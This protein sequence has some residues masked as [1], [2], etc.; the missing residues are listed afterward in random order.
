M[1]P[2]A[3][4]VRVWIGGLTQIVYNT[5]EDLHK[6]ISSGV[7]LSVG[8]A[9]PGWDVLDVQPSTSAKQVGGQVAKDPTFKALACVG[10]R[11][12]LPDQTAA[13]T[14]V[15]HAFVR[16]PFETPG[17]VNKARDIFSVFWSIKDRL[18]RFRVPKLE[19]FPAS[20]YVCA[21][22]VPSSNNPIGKHVYMAAGNQ[23]IG[24]I[25]ETFDSP[26]H[27]ERFPS[28]YQHDLSLIKATRGHTLPEVLAPSG[29]PVVDGWASIEEA[30]E[31]KPVFV[32][33]H[34]A[35]PRNRSD[36]HGHVLTKTERQECSKAIQFAIAE[37]VSYHFGTEKDTSTALLWRTV[38]S[39]HEAQQA[40]GMEDKYVVPFVEAPR[41]AVGFSGS[42]L[43][44]GTP[45]D[46]TAKAIVMQNFELNWPK[47][48]LGPN[49]EIQSVRLI[50][51][52]F[53]LPT[54]ITKHCT[55]DVS[56]AEQHTQA[57][58]STFNG[59]ETRTGAQRRSFTG[60]R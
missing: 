21:K 44:E 23:L 30:L 18:L 60:H 7:A 41:S 37:G 32:S 52:G 55:I 40:I 15:T 29:Y 54:F 9:D 39:P 8:C 17:I 10:L 2:L 35:E 59:R 51:G 56:V 25:G 19:S 43:C 33:A 14:T 22:D 58:P 16:L 1:F 48:P 31:G 49:K 20:G 26:S 34:L 12:R 4:G 57:A 28:G 27:T 11:L 47:T 53:Q 45:T 42:V 50:K 6:S 13:I 36:L 46:A 3:C 24:E 5:P 38:P